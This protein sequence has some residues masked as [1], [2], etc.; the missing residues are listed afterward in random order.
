MTTIHRPLNRADIKAAAALGKRIIPVPLRN[1]KAWA[2]YPGIGLPEDPDG[3][4]VFFSVQE[5]RMG[6]ARRALVP[7]MGSPLLAQR[8]NRYG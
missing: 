8:W 5:L 4:P 2:L 3:P 1:T 7:M 6:I